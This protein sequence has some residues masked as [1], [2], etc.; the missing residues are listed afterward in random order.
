MLTSS[1]ARVQQAVLHSAA[2]GSQSEG[3]GD[4]LGGL[5]GFSDTGSGQ[6]RRRLNSGNRDGEA[7]MLHP[8]DA[9]SG[10][11]HSRRNSGGGEVELHSVGTGLPGSGFTE[12]SL[13]DDDA[14]VDDHL[15][16]I[17]TNETKQ[18]LNMWRLAALTFFT[19]SGGPYGLEPLVKTVGPFYSIIGL[20][21][22]PWVWGMPCALMTAEL[23]SAIPE[24][25]G[26]ISWVQRT[27]G[28]FWAFQNGIWNIFSNTLDNAL[29]PVMFVDYI[30]EMMGPTFEFSFMTRFLIGA[31]MVVFLGFVNVIGVDVV[32]DGAGVF[33]I[34]VILPFLFLVL[35]GFA[36]GEVDPSDWGESNANLDFGLYVSMLLWN[37]CGY[38]SAGTCAAEVENPGKIYPRAMLLTIILTTLLYV[39]P[40]MAGVSF[41]TDY[42]AWEDGHFVTI[43]ELIGGKFLKI[44]VLVAGCVS[45]LGLLN[46]TMCTS[47][48][49]LACIAGFGY[50]PKSL[51]RIHPKY[52]TPIV[53][54]MINSVS[55]IG[56]IATGLDFEAIAQLSMWLYALTLAFEFFALMLLRSQEPELERP[57][58]IPLGYWS[59][60]LMC[61]MPLGCCVAL[62]LLSEPRTWAICGCILL[63]GAVM[64]IPYYR[65][66][67]KT[68]YVPKCLRRVCYLCCRCYSFRAVKVDDQDNGELG[69]D[70]D[71][72]YIDTKFTTNNAGAVQM[73][74]LN[75]GAASRNKFDHDNDDDDDD[76]DDVDYVDDDNLAPIRLT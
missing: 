17:D 14:G 71:D 6:I 30:E 45:S 29:Y 22:V 74:D 7:A 72:D 18:G 55:I 65:S 57:Y 25:G 73:T 58:R 5:L 2:T 48:R 8:V 70:D 51:A 64:L 52:G 23:A 21:V 15:H 12:V 59:L 41:A 27:M 49:A 28:D 66:S 76:D 3:P 69:D 11:S 67:G 47:S 34:F 61:S 13:H 63:F 36:S 42:S 9:A 75:L 20:L 32:G 31:I 62:M 37:T 33:G 56:M 68:I 40:I 4:G 35:I 16:A 39:L 10:P 19:V 60:W 54:I 26:Y 43:G 38:D 50:A 46:S 44:F 1:S 24:M 53:A